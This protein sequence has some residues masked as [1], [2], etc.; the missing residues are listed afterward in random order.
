M[1][2]PFRLRKAYG[3]TGRLDVAMPLGT[4]HLSLRRTKIGEMTSSQQKS[5]L[6]NIFFQIEVFLK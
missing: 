3:A 2:R 4:N 1:Q 6:A 5:A